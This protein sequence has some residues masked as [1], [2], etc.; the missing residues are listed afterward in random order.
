ML[1]AA[2]PVEDTKVAHE[3]PARTETPA[4]PKELPAACEKTSEG[5]CLPPRAFVKRLCQDAYPGTAIRLFEKSSPFT[6]GYVRV[7][8]MRPVNTLGGPAGESDLTFGEEVLILT[9]TGGGAASGM[10]MSG[11]GGYDVLRWDGTCATLA[12]GELARY[13]PITPR[14]APFAWQY[15]DTNIQQ[16][17]LE[18]QG[19]DLARK[20]QRKHCQGAALG[21]RSAPCIEADAKLNERIVIAVRTGMTLPAPDRIP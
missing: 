9:R 13:A 2:A 14:H 18:N 10:Q 5:L 6:R 8:S 19:I 21:R 11:M 16:A 12:D 3:D 1:A 7:K 4:P 17:L 20:T 15:I